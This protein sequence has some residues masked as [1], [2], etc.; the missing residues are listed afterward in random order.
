MIWQLLTIVDQEVLVMAITPN[1][2]VC[3][4][5]RFAMMT[6]YEVAAD[7]IVCNPI[8]APEIGTPNV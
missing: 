6:V 7:Q 4:G 1:M 5:I 8:A 2:E 3:E